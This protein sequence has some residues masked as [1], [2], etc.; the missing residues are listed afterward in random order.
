MNPTNLIVSLR[1]VLYKLENDNISNEQLELLK[2]FVLKLNFTEFNSNKSEK[3][4]MKYLSVGWYICENI[5]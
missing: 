5:L 3:D 4:L 1:Y 2:E